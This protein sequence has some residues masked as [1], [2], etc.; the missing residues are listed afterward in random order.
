DG[1]PFSMVA[2][3]QFEYGGPGRTRRFFT[4]TRLGVEYL[5]LNTA[6]PAFANSNLRQAVAYAVDRSAIAAIAGTR[7]SDDLIPPGIPGAYGS[8]YSLDLATAQALA[9]AAP[10]PVVL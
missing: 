7:A 4:H 1:V 6:R 10:P 2:A 8:V 9:G 3:L 5:A